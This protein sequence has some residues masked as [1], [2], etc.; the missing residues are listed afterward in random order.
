MFRKMPFILVA[1]IL[2]AILLGPM[3]PIELKRALYS[4]SLSIKDIIIFLLPLIIFGLLFKAVATLSS[5]ATKIIIM[6]LAFVCCSNFLSTFLSHYIGIW[7]YNFNLSMIVPSGSDGLTGLWIYH[8]PKLI[9]NDKSMFVGILLGIITA[10]LYPALAAKASAKIEIFFN[11]LLQMLV[12]FIPLFVAGFVIKLQY[13]GVISVI[14]RNYTTV[15]LFIALAQFGYILIAYYILN[16]CNFKAFMF[17][18]KN[19]LPAAISGFST[20]SSAVSMPL[21]IAGVENSTKNKDI[22]R[23]VVPITVN[24]HLIGDCFAIPILAYAILKSFGMPEPTLLTYLIFTFYFVLAKFSVA[25]I[26]GGGI[27]IMLPILE[28]YLGF[29]AEMLSLITA[30]YILLDPVIT[31]ANV[32][33]NG[34]FA[35]MIDNVCVFLDK[36]KSS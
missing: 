34:G 11:K 17:N 27:I 22:A 14:I 35:K 21:T 1:V 8:L 30:L 26:P 13:D 19:M 15:F 31:C 23:A 18:I 33:G 32:L 12:Y 10:K 3:L 4:I 24:I 16:K 7:I 25:A 6:I 36:N 2:T 28:G 20:M 29:N 5:N 9:T